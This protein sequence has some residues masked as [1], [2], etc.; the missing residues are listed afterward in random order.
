M[1]RLVVLLCALIA[2]LTP[3]VRAAGDPLPSWR[4]GAVKEALVGFVTRV[5]PPGGADF[6]PVPERIAV[7]DN[8]GTLW[9]E[10]PAYVQ[11]LFALDQI[12]KLAPRH[13]GWNETA[14]FAAVLKGDRAAMSKFSERDVA[15]LLA[16]THAGLT[17]DEF[18]V[19]ARAWLQN[20]RHP[21]FGRPFTELAYQPMLEVLAYLRAHE[22][23][24]FIVSGGGID[25]VRT[26]AEPVYGI[27]PQQVIGSSGQMKFELR[28]GRP[29]LLKLPELGSLDD[30]PGKPVNIELHIGRRPVMAF[31][32]SDGDLAMLEWTT[33]APGPRFG[34]LVHHTDAEREYAYDRQSHVGR[35]DQALDASRQ[36]GWHVVDMQR[37]WNTIF[38][39]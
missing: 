1:E 8:D 24:T 22:F 7:F 10:Q 31:G 15:Q 13:S 32:N 3:H 23:Q 35:L 36:R 38:T 16:A 17:T 20:A 25:F 26:F 27:P 34:L 19:T 11:A 9:C 28:D 33:L 30:G 12:R 2:S 14:P 37:D 39:P 4:S 29:V 18:A 6:V 5:T 21:R